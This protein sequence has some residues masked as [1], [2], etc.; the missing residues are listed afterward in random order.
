MSANE[1]C[2][3]LVAMC[4]QARTEAHIAHLGTQ[5]YAEH[6]ALGEFYTGIVDLADEYAEA[7]QG[8]HGL[9]KISP[10]RK[11]GNAEKPV[12]IISGLRSW[13]D[14]NRGFCGAEKEL[15]NLIDEILHLCDSTV[16]KLR[17]LA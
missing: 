16:Y 13:I 2:G 14:E 7:A 5:S 12:S 10:V 3:E 11:V 8:R 1:R 17:F 15:Q 4:F 6:M 9:L